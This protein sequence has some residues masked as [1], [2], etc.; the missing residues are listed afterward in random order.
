MKGRVKA[1]LIAVFLFVL[2]ATG[3]AFTDDE[4]FISPFGPTSGIF[5]S[6]IYVI[7]EGSIGI[8]NAY[9]ESLAARNFGFNYSIDASAEKG[10]TVFYN[11]V[12]SVPFGDSDDRLI[13]T[14]TIVGYDNQGTDGVLTG[15]EAIGSALCSDEGGAGMIAGVGYNLINGSLYTR[16]DTT[17]SNYMSE[18]SGSAVGV[19]TV[20]MGVMV[21]NSSYGTDGNGNPVTTSSANYSQSVSVSGEFR[22]F[23]QTSSVGLS[24]KGCNLLW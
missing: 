24:G 23:S 18:F 9:E 8:N 17:S 1:L 13:R 10:H 16:S 20:S 15:E 12:S 4:T 22:A 7:S 21:A 11:T 6:G 19:G 5:R 14:G 3:T 2:F